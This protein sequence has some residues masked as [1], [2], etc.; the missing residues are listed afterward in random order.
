MSK[1]KK[2]KDELDKDEL[3]LTAESKYMENLF[4]YISKDKKVKRKDNDTPISKADDLRNDKLNE[5]ALK[6][7]N[8]KIYQ[9]RFKRTIQLGERIKNLHIIKEIS[10][11]MINNNSKRGVENDK[12]SQSEADHL[13]FLYLTK[14]PKDKKSQK[15]IYTQDYDTDDSIDVLK[16]PIVIF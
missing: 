5:I 7:Q 4:K 16:L 3:V 10:F 2:L 13:A 14:K 8:D 11:S 6:I 12:L 9:Q 1:L 15:Y